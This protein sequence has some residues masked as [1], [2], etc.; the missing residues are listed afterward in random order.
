MSGG[1]T[2][3]PLVPSWSSNRGTATSTSRIRFLYLL[4]EMEA[5]RTGRFPDMRVLVMP[6]ALG[7]I[8][9]SR[10]KSM[11][12]RSIMRRFC[13]SSLW[14]SSAFVASMPGPMRTWVECRVNR[15]LS[16]IKPSNS[17]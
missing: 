5:C 12:I 1:L 14:S 4:S 10:V 17:R 7:T 2:A 6:A 13:V 8:E 11:L 16:Y 9:V 15:N 3:C